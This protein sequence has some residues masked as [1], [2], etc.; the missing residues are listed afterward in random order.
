MTLLLASALLS[1]GLGSCATYSQ[2]TSDAFDLFSSARFEEAAELY[3]EDG[4]TGSEFLEGAEAGMAALAG[5]DWD[6]SQ[7]LFNHA[8]DAVREVEDEAI[9]SPGQLGEH[10]L[11]WVVN[12]KVFRYSG[13]GYE[14]AALHAAL[15]MTYLAQGSLDG[16]WVETRRANQ[17]LESEEQLYETEYAAGGIGH[18]MSA[19]AYELLERYD[20]AYIDYERMAE[21]G[22]GLELAGRSLVRIATEL[23]YTDDLPRL[24]ERYGPD[25]ERPAGAANIVL[26]G[27]VGLGPYK[28]ENTIALPTGDG[29]YQWSVP[30]FQ[31]RPQPVPGLE[32]SVP[33]TTIRTTVVEDVA[34]VAKKNL[35]DR[36]AWLAAKSLVRGYFKRELTKNLA[37][38]HGGWGWLAGNLY[39]TLTER[40]DLRSW[41]T[42]PDSWHAARLFVAPGEHAIS[43]SAIGGQHV[44]VGT[45]ELEPGETM[46][47]LARTVGGLLTVHPIGGLRVDEPLPTPVGSAVAPPEG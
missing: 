21:K 7:D 13:E 29:I 11:S 16:V 23:R 4:T 35:D 38:D 12:E 45:Y 5:G 30:S 46:I 25:S 37:D 1:A 34:A 39:A 8:A 15:A 6:N 28:V 3:A 18:L 20:E 43:V 10:L 44:A 36:I 19:L 24:I 42:L 32:L 27:G 40:A 9:A 26:I 14:R 22:V 47:L 31:R 33:G 41:Q 2:R 17:L